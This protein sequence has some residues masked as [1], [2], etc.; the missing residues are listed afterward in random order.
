MFS[1]CELELFLNQ[2]KLF[3][4]RTSFIIILSRLHVFRRGVGAV[5]CYISQLY[6]VRGELILI[7]EACLYY[8]KYKITRVV[9]E[10][11]LLIKQLNHRDWHYLWLGQQDPTTSTHMRT[12]VLACLART[13]P[14]ACNHTHAHTRD[15]TP[16]VRRRHPCFLV[17]RLYDQRQ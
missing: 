1:L 2:I 8:P 9:L 10:L 12:V 7:H 11:R 13:H 17:G 5:G 14:K 3:S 15:R 4:I 16:A 6:L